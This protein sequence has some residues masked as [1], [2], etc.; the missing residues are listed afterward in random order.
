MP[1]ES[2]TLNFYGVNKDVDPY[3]LD[4]TK[5]SDCMNV[6]FR[7]GRSS[8]S[9]VFAEKA[10]LTF[11][12]TY[13]IPSLT[14]G[15]PTVFYGTEDAIYQEKAGTF[16]NVGSGTYT[17]NHWDGTFFGQ[18]IIMT[19]GKDAPQ[20]KGE[21]D[22]NFKALANFPDKTTA[23]IIRSFKGFLVATRLVKDS[24]EDH[25]SIM[26]SDVADPGMLPSSWA[27]APDNLAGRVDLIEE[28][29]NIVGMELLRDRLLIYKNNSVY[30]MNYVGGNQVFSFKQIMRGLGALNKN[31]IIEFDNRHFVVDTGQ[32]YVTDGL[33]KTDVGNNKMYEYFS[34]TVSYSNLDKVFMAKSPDAKELF[35]CYR[36]KSG[37]GGCDR[38]IVWNWEEDTWTIQNLPE[39]IYAHSLIQSREN[40]PTW[41]N[42]P[43]V[44]WD[45][46][47]GTWAFDTL[48]LARGLYGLQYDSETLLTYGAA[49]EL[50]HYYEDSYLERTGFSLGDDR[51]VKHIKQIIPNIATDGDVRFYVGA[52]MEQDTGY[53]WKGP[54]TYNTSQKN[55]ITCRVSGRHLGIRILSRNMPE[56]GRMTVV[57]ETVGER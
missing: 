22:A 38:A 51:S 43:A 37:D 54:F 56:V 6:Q 41:G 32:F 2:T 15:V 33:N 27:A 4:P 30:S 1:N 48:K 11:K 21:G 49:E 10:T 42:Q 7:Q 23:G 28:P 31:C 47:I 17:S 19:N 3:A 46:A 29:S 45:T 50:P 36:T 14:A 5:W 12:P 53:R 39:V 13:F 57:Y 55:R 26:W 18:V 16:T 24:I 8:G 44:T 52:E 20:S 25:H 35:I 9:S 40:P 34:D